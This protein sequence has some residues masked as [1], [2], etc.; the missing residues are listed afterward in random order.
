MHSEQMKEN[1]NKIRSLDRGIQ[2]IEPE[3]ERVSEK[4]LERIK[5]V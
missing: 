2:Q 1:N 3:C 5:T 4:K